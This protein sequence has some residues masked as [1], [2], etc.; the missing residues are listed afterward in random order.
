MINENELQISSK[1]YTNKDFA[2]IYPELLELAKKL[3]NIWDPSSSNES[4]P[5]VVLL[6]LLAFIGDKNTYYID[7]NVLEIFMPSATQE[8]S[9]RKLSEMNGYEMGYYNSAEVDVTF[10]YKG[11]MSNSDGNVTF[12]LPAYSTVVTGTDSAVTYVLLDRVELAERGV[13]VRKRAIE[14]TL[15]YL[16]GT[17]N[18][19]IQLNS[20]DDSNRLYFP[21]R[22]VAV[23]GIFISNVDEINSIWKPVD[24]LNT[25]TPLTKCFKF[26]FDSIRNL[27]YIEFP[28]DIATLI[29]SG[30][31]IKYI[32][33][34]GTDGNIKASFLNKLYNSTNLN[35]FATWS[36]DTAKTTLAV[37]M[38]DLVISN[39][40]ASMSGRNP[41]GIDEAYNSFKKV[42]GTFTTLVT[43]RDYANFIYKLNGQYRVS[44]VQVADRRTDIN[45]SNNLITF[46]EFGTH[47]TSNENRA[48]IT[49]FDLVIYPLNSTN[50][51]YDKDSYYNSFKR[52][53]DLQNKLSTDLE[54]AKIISHDIKYP[55]E[56]G[57]FL[58]KNYYKLNVKITTITKVN[59]AEANAIIGNIKTA[60]YKNFNA[61]EVDFGYEIPFDSI[62]TVIQQA[63]ARIKN[64]SLDE[65][66][67][68][69]KVLKVNTS[70]T[71]VD[72]LTVDNT[73]SSEHQK[74]LAKNI[75]AG[76]VSLFDYYDDFEFEFYQE[77]R[78]GVSPII[79]NLKS[80]STSIPISKTSLASGYMLQENEVIQL[81]GPNLTTKITY[82]SY[83]NFNYVGVGANV[84]AGVE[85][86][87]V[88]GETLKI[89]YTDTNDVEKNITY[90]SGDIIKVSGFTLESTATSSRAKI[91][92]SFNG[93]NIDM[94][95]LT[96]NETIEIRD[97]VKSTLS[98]TWKCYW[99]LDERKNPDNCLFATG[100]DEIILSE[101]ESFIYT[102]DAMT[103][104]VI[105]GSGT[106]LTLDNPST[107]DSA[108]ILDR[109][110]L[111]SK[112]KIDDKGLA[113]FSSFD[114]K[115]VNFAL[116][117]LTIQEMSIYAFGQGTTVKI[118]DIQSGKTQIDNDLISIPDTATIEY[119][120]AGET[121][122]TQ[123]SQY[124]ISGEKWL[125][126]SRLDFNT[127]P[128]IYQKIGVG[129]EITFT[130][131]NN[132]QIPVTKEPDKETVF[133]LNIPFYRSGGDDIDLSVVRFVNQTVE[134]SYD[135]TALVY[136]N[137]TTPIL[138]QRNADTKL[139]SYEVK[140]YI[141]PLSLPIIS[142]SGKY[143]LIM[144]YWNKPE[145]S[146]VSSIVLSAVGGGTISKYNQTGS[147]GTLFSGLNIMKLN[148]TVNELTVTI[149][150]SNLSTTSDTL[151]IGEISVINDLNYER[152]GWDS[153]ST[154]VTEKL[155][156]TISTLATKTIDGVDRDIFFYNSALDSSH[157]IEVEDTSSQYALFDY[158]NIA[159][160]FTISEIDVDGSTIS[161]ARSSRL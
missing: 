116:N 26:G 38:N 33:T 95:S 83:V 46:D 50:D 148:G 32:V 27:P 134:I 115:V 11:L 12:Y 55:L 14:G 51:N 139:I 19:S 127:G 92:K 123:V 109:A 86:K 128:E 36:T 73:N 157:L 99:L 1:S 143:S 39:E 118:S 84:P 5:G 81:I 117:N 159:N 40:S 21:E 146:S 78:T 60:L 135:V 79:K 154:L 112:E 91:T 111:I 90:S 141:S 20:L 15:Q 97:F 121:N 6:K 122:F 156:S 7:K 137:A 155:L 28:A 93:V 66:Q 120:E 130:Q 105:L 37:S 52:K 101:G 106:K 102:D 2:S 82:P 107:S 147:D 153:T 72:Y 70:Q 100:K 45:Y 87:L 22:F 98:K 4:D 89:N 53:T 3:T 24:N 124:S 110:K 132:T 68:S 58:Y 108:W 49:P 48:N 160:Q 31:D 63:D 126:R 41:E 152:F 65:P 94:N 136:N 13:S 56:D 150:G 114:W 8:S 10:M 104:L 88:S 161:I 71:E 142:V 16:R 85:H 113:A 35:D 64:V 76:R 129:Q 131:D 103:E 74:L 62:L 158:N 17:D 140:N 144:F 67:L 80:V 30:L 34:Q 125:V 77:V 96:V 47:L 23:N 18:S 57:V 43:C 42:V 54:D 69:T 151:S 9:M 145:D 61:R 138:L 44:N 75:L 29:G 119:K 133:K 149:T 59:N 25:E